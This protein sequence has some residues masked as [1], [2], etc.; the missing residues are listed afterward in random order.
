MFDRAGSTQDRK[1]AHREDMMSWRK[2]MALVGGGGTGAMAGAAA[3]SVIPGL[4][5]VTGAVF[6]GVFGALAAV[7]AIDGQG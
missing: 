4:G 1:N 2:L 7:S 6:G 3:A 5:T